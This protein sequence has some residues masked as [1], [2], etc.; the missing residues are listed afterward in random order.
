MERLFAKIP[1]WAAGPKRLVTN[2]EVATMRAS[3]LLFEPAKTPFP[4]YGSLHFND[5][6]I[7]TNSSIKL[8]DEF[9]IGPN[10]IWEY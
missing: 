2:S 6:P 10:C 3:N 5:N 8:D 4:A 1:F 7:D 9:C